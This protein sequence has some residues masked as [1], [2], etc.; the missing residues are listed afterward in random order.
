MLSTSE[1]VNGL[2]GNLIENLM[3]RYVDRFPEPACLLLNKIGFVADTF[4]DELRQVLKTSLTKLF[5]E[6]PV[7]IEQNLADTVIMPLLTQAVAVSLYAG[8]TPDFDALRG[9]LDRLKQHEL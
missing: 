7:L 9:D 4:E 8:E 1:I 6:Y 3:E 2:V 5:G